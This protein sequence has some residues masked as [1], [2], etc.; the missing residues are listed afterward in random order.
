MKNIYLQL[1][2]LH[3]TCP[4]VV[5]ATVTGSVGSTPQKPGSSALFDA[6]GLISGTVGGGVVEGKVQNFSMKAVASGDS[7]HLTFYLNR[8]ASAGEDALCGGHNTVLIDS[9]PCEY[10]SVFKQIERSLSN[11]VPGVLITR[12]SHIESNRVL[13]GRFWMT[14]ND[15]PVLPQQILEKI[16][17]E[18]RNILINSDATDFR[19]IRISEQDEVASDLFFLEPVFPN[20]SLI[21]AGAGHIG[22]ALAHLGSLLDFEVTVIDDRDEYANSTNIID[23]DHIIVDNI[24]KA[25]GELRKTSDTFIVI[26]TR[27][28][29]D[30]AEALKACIGSKAGYI[31]MIGSRNKVATFRSNFLEKGWAT[32]EQWDSIHTPVGVDINSV[33]VQEIAVSIAAELVKTRNAKHEPGQSRARRSQTQ[34]AKR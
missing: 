30:D 11:R 2:D 21:I 12:V 33:T 14:E 18:V 25:I 6:A 17:P 15:K 29:N 22:K 20:P 8:D 16:A 9:R 7:F 4:N 27:G 23:A 32:T 19:E 24:G 3:E 5:L 1:L 31:G 13:I 10:L 26:V 28:H 34:N